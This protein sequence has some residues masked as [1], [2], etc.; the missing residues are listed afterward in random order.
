M[1]GFNNM[2][3][4][5]GIKADINVVDAPTAQNVVVE[6]PSQAE[7]ATSAEVERELAGQ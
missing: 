6:A 2:G 4:D 1:D 5:N 7:K 3:E